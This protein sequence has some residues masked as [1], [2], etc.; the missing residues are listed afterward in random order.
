[1]Y[2]E[3]DGH[4]YIIKVLLGE[5]AK[6]RE[7]NKVERIVAG[8][9]EILNALFERTYARLQPVTKRVFLTLCSWRSLVPQL[10]LEAVLLR[11]ANDKM[12]VAAAVEELVQSSFVERTIASDST[13]F[14]DVALVASV[15]G[16]RKLETTPMRPA[17]DADVEFLQQI[18]ATSTSALRHGVRPRIERLFQFTASRLAAGRMKL[19]EVVPSL[20]FVCRQY[21][22]AWLM[23]AKLYEEMGTI[24]GLVK[25]SECLRRFLEQPQS[26]ADERIGWD[27]LAQIYRLLGDWTGAAQAQIRICKLPDALY[28]AFSNAANSLNRLFNE[29]YLAMDSDEKRLLYRELAELMEQRKAEADATELSRLA[30]LYLHLHDTSRAREIAEEGL[31]IEAENEHCVRL[32]HRLGRSV[33]A[34]EDGGGWVISRSPIPLLPER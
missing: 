25:A 16:R 17:I 28:S 6:S 19:D 31:A 23:L 27:Q 13:V 22:P 18:G 3:A 11:P 21:A 2:E 7:L 4:P 30:W 1:M 29:N 24:A 12:D 15:F 8:K 20:E 10:A 14:L 9:D 32:L 26:T 5:V 33:G 34:A